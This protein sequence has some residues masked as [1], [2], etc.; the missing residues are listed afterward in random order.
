MKRTVFS[1]IC[2]ILA[3]LFAGCSAP[4]LK[5]A[6]DYKFGYIS[7]RQDGLLETSVYSVKSVDD[8]SDTTVNPPFIITGEGT[9]TVNLYRDY[10]EEYLFKL[11][12]ELTFT[13]KYHYTQSDTYSEEFTNTFTSASYAYI[14]SETFTAKSTQKVFETSVPVIE[15]GAYTAKKAYYTVNSNYEKTAKGY[16]ITSSV[17]DGGQEGA[18]TMQTDANKNFS[19][20]IKERFVDNE[21]IFLAL[22]L[23]TLNTSFTDSFKVPDPL[24]GVIQSVSVQADTN[25]QQKKFT[26]PANPDTEKD[27]DCV[28]LSAALGGKY[29]GSNTVMYFTHDYSVNYLKNGEAISRNISLLLEIKQGNLVYT[30]DSYDNYAE[31]S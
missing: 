22:R 7:E 24:S 16:L 23:Q 4:V 10:A 26:D 25:M 21:F 13:G 20:E 1:A 18:E 17:T 8:I 29:K 28:V 14:N 11:V 30:L 5:I 27:F 2:L 31:K 12:T 3:V 15:N 9:Y 19:S 6:N